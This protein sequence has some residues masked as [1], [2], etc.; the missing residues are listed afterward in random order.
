MEPINTNVN[1]D[2]KGRV[3]LIRVCEEQ[4]VKEVK[5]TCT[6]NRVEGVDEY[7]SSNVNGEVQPMDVPR[8][9]EDGDNLADVMDDD[10]EDNTELD[11]GD[12]LTRREEGG[13][14]EAVGSLMEIS[15]VEEFEDCIRKS[16][17]VDKNK[18]AESLGK[19][20]EDGTRVAE[21]MMKEKKG[22][23]THILGSMRSL[24]RSSRAR[25]GINL[26]VLLGH[27]HSS[28]QINGPG[29]IQH[30]G[31]GISQPNGWTA[32]GPIVLDSKSGNGDTFSV[33]ISE[34]IS[35]KMKPRNNKG[36]RKVGARNS[37]L[38][39]GFSGFTRRLG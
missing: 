9:E 29:T 10:V 18:N 38:V 20:I 7:V 28:T 15:I 25:S 12:L 33:S 8:V 17:E 36:K 23:Q 39:S 32:H 1:L 21:T 19:A 34:S 13:E 27:K 35:N 30:H 6:C 5:A 11:E 4:I 14:V 26:E 3:Y 31:S 22:G 16:T 37:M 24:N 2:C